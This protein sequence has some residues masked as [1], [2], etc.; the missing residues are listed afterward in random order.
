MDFVRK[1]SFLVFIFCVLISLRNQNAQ[2]NKVLPNHEA[3]EELFPDE[4]FPDE[5]FQSG[6]AY[7]YRGLKKTN[8][9]SQNEA[10]KT[11]ELLQSGDDYAY[12]KLKNEN[13]QNEAVKSEKLFQSG[14]ESGYRSFKKALFNLNES[15]IS[16]FDEAESLR[17]D[18]YSDSCPLAEEIIRLT[19]RDVYSQRP[20]LVPSLLRLVFHDCFVEGCDASLLLDPTDVNESEKQSP[21]NESLKGFDVID[22]IKFKL[23]DA[24]P[25]VV[26]CADI[27]VLAA[28][29]S[30]VLTGGPFYP[31]HTGRRDSNASFPDVAK[32]ELPG[33]QDDLPRI[34]G[35]FSAKGFDERET[36]SL[37]GGH[38]TG[39]VHCKFFVNRLYNFRE[40]GVPDP[41][42]DSDFVNMLRSKCS[43]ILASLPHSSASQSPAPSPESSS[44]PVSSTSQEDEPAMKLDFEGP[45]S[46]FGSLYYRSLLQGKGLLHV[47]QQ[48]T[49]GEETETWVRAYASDVSL[50]QKDFT[51]VMIKLSNFRVLT[52]S[53]GQV[54]SNCREVNT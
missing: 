26:S 9:Y 47:D 1:L 13:S 23:E 16:D 18:F 28:R 15:M 8:K 42:M 27:L 51:L 46:G 12:R 35:L 48:L 41:T 53:M 34:I 50:F 2:T 39:R 43:Q 29:E 40:T 45:G 11:E 6:D 3:K 30:V 19:V 37:L 10:E 7:A 38:S 54:R 14:D 5:L 44:S 31:L 22:I 17:Y 36:V 52:G 24:C 32:V 4:L 33:P 21:P 20:D 49:A 25:G